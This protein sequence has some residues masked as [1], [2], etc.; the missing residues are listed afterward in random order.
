MES[1]PLTAAAATPP[2]V[3][4]E[5]F[6][7][8]G[9]LVALEGECDV[10]AARLV[11][12]GLRDG[13]DEGHRHFVIDLTGATLL[14]CAALGALLGALRPLRSESE[15][16]VLLAGAQG[17]VARVLTILA[18]DELFDVHPTREAAIA[19]LA[20]PA[21]SCGAGW[22]AVTGERPL[23]ARAVATD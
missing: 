11:A 12:H 3:H 5:R 15:A 17:V 14:D 23:V 6:G 1:V 4:C 21:A 20:D 18:I 13:I 9:L 16:A 7:T 10:S 19:R 22:R 8:G 2:R